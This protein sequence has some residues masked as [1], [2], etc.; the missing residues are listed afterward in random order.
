[1]TW[2][3]N[4]L[5]LARIVLLLPIMWLL[6]STADPLGL[7]LAFALF[8]VAALTDL[9]DG[10]LARRL[11]C[12]TNIGAFLDPL[13]DKIVS[14]VLLVF[15]ACRAPDWVPLW[16]VLLLLSREFAVQ[17]FRS[18]APCVGVLIGTDRLSKLKTFFQLVTV[19]AVMVG[20]GWERLA[21]LANGV[22]LIALVLALL[23]AYISMIRLFMRN[24]DLWSRRPLTME[25]R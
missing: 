18:L 22:A 24:T 20:L 2:L 6:T 4:T 17:G 19:G 15:L 23:S 5:T 8:L 3:P 25:R 21:W 14:N 1:M 9:A 13:A 12:V 11:H 7:Q 10:W 16:M